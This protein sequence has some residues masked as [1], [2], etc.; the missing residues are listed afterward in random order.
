MTYLI[1]GYNEK[2]DEE[3]KRNNKTKKRGK[4]LS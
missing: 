4:I 2:K 1:G 3:H